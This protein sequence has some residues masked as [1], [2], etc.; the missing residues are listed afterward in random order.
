MMTVEGDNA[1]E[2]VAMS[3]EDLLMNTTHQ[4]SIILLLKFLGGYPTA[5]NPHTE[6]YSDQ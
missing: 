3:I 5:S 1:D 4:D 2:V 6:I